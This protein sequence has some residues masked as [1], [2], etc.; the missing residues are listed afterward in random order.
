MHSPKLE[1]LPTD[2]LQEGN[3]TQKEGGQLQSQAV[4]SVCYFLPGDIAVWLTHIKPSTTM[5][6]ELFF[7]GEKNPTL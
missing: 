3:G 5:G 7:V 2:V 1:E 6:N 4:Q